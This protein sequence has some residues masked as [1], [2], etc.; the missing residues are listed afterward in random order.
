[1]AD[2]LAYRTIL[3]NNI[4]AEFGKDLLANEIANNDYED[5]IVLNNAGS[6][7][8]NIIDSVSVD[9]IYG[10][11]NDGEYN[12]HNVTIDIDQFKK[13]EFPI[14]T[15]QELQS[16]TKLAAKLTVKAREALKEAEDLYVID[17]VISGV[18]ENN[19]IGSALEPYDCSTPDKALALVEQFKIKLNKNGVTKDNRV[20]IA[21]TEFSTLLLRSSAATAIANSKINATDNSIRLGY[22]GTLYG[23]RIYEYDRA[24][25]DDNANVILATHK[26][27]NTKAEQFEGVEVVKNKVGETKVAP[28]AVYGAGV[29]HAKSAKALVSFQ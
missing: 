5:E 4:E 14:T 20:I 16:S 17:K 24:D 3:S 12:S 22:V 8:L 1:M 18:T 28:V 2:G 29:V 26:K 7:T 6:V 23:F 19:T 9:D 25:D 13:A 21:P 11:D 10:E 15:K 27:L